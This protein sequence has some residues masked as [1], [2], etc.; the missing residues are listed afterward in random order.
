MGAGDLAGV[1]NPAL[2]SRESSKRGF[3]GCAFRQS[4]P[5][6]PVEFCKDFTGAQMGSTVKDHRCST[7]PEVFS[8][9]PMTMNKVS[10]ITK[11]LPHASTSIASSR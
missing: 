9:G 4:K 8:S 1:V 11:P 3:K 5:A 2:A 7:V 10:A 6:R